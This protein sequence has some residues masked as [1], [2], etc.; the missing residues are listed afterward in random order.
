PGAAGCLDS[1]GKPI[2]LNG[3]TWTPSPGVSK[4]GEYRGVTV[5]GNQTWAG[6]PTVWNQHGYRVNNNSF[7]MA[8]A[9]PPPQQPPPGFI[10]DAGP[11]Q[12]VTVGQAMTLSATTNFD[13]VCFQ[14]GFLWYDGPTFIAQ[15]QT[16]TV[17][18]TLSVGQHTIT[19]RG[20]ANTGTMQAEDT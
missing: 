8:V 3:F 17:P 16:V 18:V 13:P 19:L 20:F 14:C 7:R 12:T 10:V 9:V 15:G 4:A 6:S 1:N 11:D 5:F 2:V